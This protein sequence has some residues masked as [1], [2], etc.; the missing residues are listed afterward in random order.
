[1]PLRVEMKSTSFELW[2]EEGLAFDVNPALFV[3]LDH[4]P[5]IW[6]VR[7]IALFGPRF[8]AVGL[9]IGRVRTA[10]EFEQ[11]WE[12]WLR[13]ERRLLLARVEGRAADPSEDNSYKML[14]AVLDGNESLAA[15]LLNLRPASDAP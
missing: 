14:K 15:A 10:P 8:K 1:M 3:R 11:G 4:D 2:T 13:L 12:A 6:T 9:E 7:G 5:I